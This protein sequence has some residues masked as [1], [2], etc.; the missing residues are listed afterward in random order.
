MVAILNLRPKMG[1]QYGNNHW[2]E[3]LAMKLAIFN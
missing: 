2:C 1:S 3:F